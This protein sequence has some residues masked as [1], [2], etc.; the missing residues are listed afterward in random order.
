MK[1]IKQAS[2][3]KMVEDFKEKAE[4]RSLTSPEGH[5]SSFGKS[6]IEMLPALK[7][8]AEERDKER[9][10]KQ[11]EQAKKR[12]DRFPWVRVADGIRRR[13]WSAVQIFSQN[14]KTPKPYRRGEFK[15]IVGCSEKEFRAHIM[16]FW[17]RDGSWG[18]HNYGK[19]DGWQI[20]HIV[21]ISYFKEIWASGD[22]ETIMQYDQIINHFTNL[23]P[24]TTS[25][26]L[27]KSDAK[28]EWVQLEHGKLWS[29]FH[30]ETYGTGSRERILALWK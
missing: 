14:K 20:D 1:Q 3:E 24:K 6:W 23:H 12:K 27:K 11:N 9:K 18:L 17:P 16:S 15:N 21:P 30:E 8:L 26:N 4:S 10:K 28:P 2:K 19:R 22:W 25:E 5:L 13:T 7:A 29:S